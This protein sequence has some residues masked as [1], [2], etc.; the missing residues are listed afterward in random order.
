ML[1]IFCGHSGWGNRD[2][3]GDDSSA[4]QSDTQPR[5]M[6]TRTPAHLS[7][8]YPVG[9]GWATLLIRSASVPTRLLPADAH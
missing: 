4:F 6:M 8:P 9:T 5:A 2:A 3:L 1:Y 7:C